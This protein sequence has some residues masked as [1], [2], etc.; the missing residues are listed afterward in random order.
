M[1]GA[2]GDLF[3]AGFT[4][5]LD[6]NKLAVQVS[7]S[8]QR[9]LEPLDL[10]GGRACVHL[11]IEGLTDWPLFLMYVKIATLESDEQGLKERRSLP[12]SPLSQ[13]R[14]PS[15]DTRAVGN[16]APRRAW[17]S[18]QSKPHGDNSMDLVEVVSQEV[19]SPSSYQH[20]PAVQMPPGMFQQVRP[21]SEQRR[22]LQGFFLRAVPPSLAALSKAV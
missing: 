13:W 7:E 19:L 5:D 10:R 20:S 12:K 16:R 1:Y 11:G 15:I 6:Y 18:A 21:V 4:G 14:D 2:N 17:R 9:K 22:R 3:R 8:M